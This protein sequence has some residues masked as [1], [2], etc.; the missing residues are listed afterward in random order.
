MAK[1]III[2]LLSSLLFACAS[3]PK[4][5]TP[6]NFSMEKSDDNKLN[7]YLLEQRQLAGLSDEET[8]MMLLEDG[9]DA[10]ITRVS[11]I[12]LAQQSVDLQYY[13]FH[14]DLSGNLLTAAL[15][16]A[17]ERGV[18]IRLL[19]D[20]MDLEGQDI[21]IAKL[22]A[23]PNL[24]IRIFNPFLRSKKRTR[25]LISDF[26]TVTR[27]MHNKTFTVDSSISILG[28]RNVGDQYYGAHSDVA[29]GDL[30]IVFA[31][32]EVQEVQ[33][34]FDLY[35]NSDI[36]YGINLLTDYQAKTDTLEEITAF[37]NT[38]VEQYR[39]SQYAAALRE[40]DLFDLIKSKKVTVFTGHTTVLYDD[41][42][43]VVS[44]RESK[45]YHLVPKL[46]PYIE[47]A[48]QEII[49][50]SP[51]FVPGVEGVAFF[52][53]LIERGIKVKI[54]TNSL[55]SNDVPVVHSGYSRYRKELLE[56]GVDLYEI[57]SNDIGFLANYNDN[58]ASSTASKLSLHAKY[59]V[60][61]RK[62]TFI[63]SLNLDPR[64][65]DENTEIG[66]IA[67]S[68][69][70]GQYAGNDFDN[71]IRKTAFKLSLVD[72]DII[73]TKKNNGETITYE[74]EPYSN[75]WDRFKNSFM[76]LLPLES[77]L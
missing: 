30:D 63:G 8:I 59:F 27:R 28:G 37:L 71:N 55:K 2:L 62:V 5:T 21:D 73:W 25:Q 24:E 48:E 65:R 33:R 13:Q 61:D 66:V 43:K 49:I 60:I 35:W 45:E 40:N 72:G 10:F 39:N 58:R 22:N 67:K 26:G 31:G 44:S 7:N 70:L 1:H 17:A 32:S 41:P 53:K 75:W 76:Q 54:L 77:Q 52:K 6:D 50:I 14:N 16:Q 38:F 19:V 11:L 18:R 64:S 9:V 46:H 23:H 4:N 69:S 12:Q 42:L 15:W 74:T 51:Y 47:S 57:D 68:I 34:S 29:F 56:L 20:D 3:L 36:T